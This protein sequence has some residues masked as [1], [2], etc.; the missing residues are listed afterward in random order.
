MHGS[1]TE[2]VKKISPRNYRQGRRIV[3]S[4]IHFQVHN[5]IFAPL[6]F[7]KW[8]CL[9]LLVCDYKEGARASNSHALPAPPLSDPLQAFA[10]L[11]HMSHSQGIDLCSPTLHASVVFASLFGLFI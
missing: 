6:L 3:Y 7:L 1:K 8:Y 2:I 10:V 5:H 11:I 4:L 9:L